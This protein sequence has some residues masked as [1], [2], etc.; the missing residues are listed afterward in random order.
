MLI[1]DRIATFSVEDK[2]RFL[3]FLSQGICLYARGLA[4]DDRK[5]AELR[6]SQSD[7]IVE[8]L[9]RLFE[10]SEHYY[11]RD[12]A[13]RPDADLFQ[14]LQNLEELSQLRGIVSSAS[15]YALRRFPAALRT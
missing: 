13:E 8:I 12:G 15:E 9:H 5:P 11:N 1:A 14:T 6:L 2:I 10:Q 3:S 4:S 7:G